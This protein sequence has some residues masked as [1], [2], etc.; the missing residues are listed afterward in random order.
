MGELLV[1]GAALRQ[2]A[3]LKTTHVEQQV[4]IVLTVHG[5]EAVLPLNCS[6]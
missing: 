3:A 6:H 1:A 4:G 2:D 5:H